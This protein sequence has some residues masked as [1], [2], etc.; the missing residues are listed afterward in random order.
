MYIKLL[1]NMIFDINKI[2]IGYNWQKKPLKLC[3]Q[4]DDNYI[5]N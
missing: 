3:A 1:K 4:I 2:I 5:K